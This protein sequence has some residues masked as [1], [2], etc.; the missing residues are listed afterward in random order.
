MNSIQ[1]RLVVLLKEIDEICVKN[2]IKYALCGRTAKDAYK[3]HIF[4]GE[5]MYASVLMNVKDFIK[6]RRIV[7][8]KFKKTRAVESIMD[9]PDFP[10]GRAMRYVDEESTFLYGHTAHKFRHNGIFVTIQQCRCM[11]KNKFLKKV[12]TKLD[13]VINFGTKTSL[14]GMGPKKRVA[15]KCLKVLGKLIGEASVV[16]MV[17]RLQN[18]FLK[19]ARNI[20]RH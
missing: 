15:F 10:E 17:I 14:E 18:M 3:D 12:I 20:L 8:H 1:K 7:K 9:Y 6:F 13:E 11:P 16:R 19:R 5:Y 4:L 2:N